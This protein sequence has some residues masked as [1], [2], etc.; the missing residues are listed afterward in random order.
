MKKKKRRKSHVPFRVNLLFLTVFALF[1]VLILRLGLVQIVYGE[2]YEREVEK[3]QDVT[4]STPVP[5][6]KM[7]DRYNRVIVD[8]TS[9]NTITYTR[10]QGNTAEERLRI[11]KKLATMIDVPYTTNV[12]DIPEN[13]KNKDAKNVVKITERDMKDYWIMLHPKEADQ[14]ITHCINVS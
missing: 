7:Y 1:S 12:I 10:F 9:L 5:R 14:K 11:A 8:N 4:V 6:G 13:K 3:T 2:N